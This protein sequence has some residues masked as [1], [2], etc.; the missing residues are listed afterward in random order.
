M[1]LLDHD[2]VFR[3]PATMYKGK[4]GMDGVDGIPNG[5]LEICH[6][7]GSNPNF[8]VLVEDREN[9]KT[10]T[11]FIRSAMFGFGEFLG[12]YHLALFAHNRSYRQW[13]SDDITKIIGVMRVYAE[14]EANAESI[15][16]STQRMG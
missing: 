3:L 4:N 5:V 10:F 16:P 13:Q 7:L 6:A 14:A 15:L 8:R 11:F 1:R 9:G 2:H 12:N